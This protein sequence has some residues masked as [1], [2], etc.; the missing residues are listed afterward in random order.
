MRVKDI[1][2]CK[3]IM[4]FMFG[5]MYLA[6]MYG[7]SELPDYSSMSYETLNSSLLRAAHKGNI[8]AIESLLKHKAYVNVDN[9][10]GFQPIHFAARSGNID[11]FLL[12]LSKGARI[13][14]SDF[15]GLEPIHVAAAYEKN[16]VIDCC[17]QKGVYIHSTSD[18]GYQ[19]IHSAALSG[20][21]KSIEFLLEKGAYYDATDRAQDTPL[22]LAAA[23]GH[24]DALK[25]LLAY[26]YIQKGP[27]Q[28]YERIA[29]MVSVLQPQIPTVIM[30]LILEYKGLETVK[31]GVITDFVFPSEG[32]KNERQL[33]PREHARK[34]ASA[35]QN[36]D[37]K[38]AIKRCIQLFETNHTHCIGYLINKAMQVPVLTNSDPEEW[39]PIK[40]APGQ[41]ML[42]VTEPE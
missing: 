3:N 36:P 21:T 37:K 32:M 8:A 18:R 11:V 2:F 10:H 40:L 1:R 42:Q 31:E 41:E 39:E 15:N 25:L 9:T 7:L 24:Y 17:L 22:H 28:E 29:S 19:P 6:H 4:A 26:E 33:T 35:E 34:Q 23:E 16:E 27:E 20:K 30:S 13:D 5:L 38:T 12:L 14:V